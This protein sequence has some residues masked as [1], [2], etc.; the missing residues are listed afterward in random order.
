[1]YIKL[2]FCLTI[3]SCNGPNKEGVASLNVNK[4]EPSETQISKSDLKTP[5]IVEVNMGFLVLKNTYNHEDKLTIYNGNRTIWKNFIF[6]DN[7][8][9]KALN[10][11]AIKAENTLLIFKYLGKEN[12]FYK[13]VVS[14]NPNI[15][16]YI[17][18][19]D[20]HFKIQTI[21]EH[22]LAVFS[23]E[24]DEKS[25]PLRSDSS[26]KSKKYSIDKNS[27]YYPVKISGNWLMVRDDNDKD[28]WIKWCDDNGN[29]IINLFYDA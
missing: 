12:G 28:F 25:N 4:K 24:F 1:M 27:F 17:K 6:N 18:D 7:F 22:I 9:D 23:V 20:A 3:L 13:I 19:S 8:N 16:K 11:Y 14:D 26:E 2:L 10:P 5:S 21:E 29:L 15:I